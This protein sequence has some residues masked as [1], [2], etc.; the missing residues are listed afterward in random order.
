[1]SAYNSKQKDAVGLGNLFRIQIPPT[2]EE[3]MQFTAKTAKQM[4]VVVL[5]AVLAAWVGAQWG[6]Q[7]MNRLEAKP[8]ITLVD[9]DWKPCPQC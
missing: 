2:E 4:A 7:H 1:M 6:V 3:Y 8:Q 5:V 9:D